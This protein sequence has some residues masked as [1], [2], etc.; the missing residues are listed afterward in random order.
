VAALLLVSGLLGAPASAR[1]RAS[2]E[3]TS[4]DPIDVET[5]PRP[6]AWASLV[7]QPITIDGR[8]D[9]PAWQAATPISDFVQSQPRVGHPATERTVA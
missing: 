6:E 8:L 7:E 3:P 2:D 1:G 4:S 5:A 9:E